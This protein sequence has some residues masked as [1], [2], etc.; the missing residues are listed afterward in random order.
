MVSSNFFIDSMNNFILENNLIREG[1]KIVVAVSGGIDSMVLLHSLLQLKDQWKL[2]LII[3][4]FNHQ[5]R[6]KEADED[7]E[8]VRSIAENKRIDFYVERA[9]TSLVAENQKLSIQEAARNLRYAFFTKVRVSSGLSKIA[10]GHNA[11]DNTETILMNLFRGAGVHGLTGIP[12]SRSDNGVIRPIMFATRQDIETYALENRIPYRVDSSNLKSDYTRNYIRHNILPAIRE[13][14]NP[15]IAV[16]L[17]RT[18]K[19]FGDLEN[20]ISDTVN[21][22]LHEIILSKSTGE[23]I[24]DLKQLHSKQKFLQDYY[25]YYTVKN[26][27]KKE[28]NFTT[29]RAILKTSYSETGSSC[30][31]GFD[32]IFY[33]DREQGILKRYITPSPFQYDITVGKQYKFEDFSFESGFTQNADINNN[34]LEEYIDADLIGEKLH[35]RNWNDGDWFFPLGMQEK[36]KLSDFFIDQKIS[37]F[38]K[39]KIPVLEC[40]GKIIWVCGLRLDDRYKITN[41]TRKILKLKFNYNY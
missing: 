17:G 26:F 7:E 12:V 28:I 18:S 9:N 21:S 10:T 11:D 31:A 37:I 20:F 3:A 39:T 35:L 22:N 27:F 36:K 19:L 34:P 1:E 38:N 23:V 41:K 13:K 40:D 14:I 2:T 24:I 25:L 29:V 15:N 5:L 8:F 4:H 33:K 30:S 16:V 32:L 6:G